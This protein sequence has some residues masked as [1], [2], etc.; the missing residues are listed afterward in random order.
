MPT[1]HDRHP[2]ERDTG[3]GAPP[4]AVPLMFSTRRVR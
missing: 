2:P 1:V 3:T 4:A